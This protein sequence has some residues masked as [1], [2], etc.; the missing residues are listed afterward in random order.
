MRDSFRLLHLSDLHFGLEDRAA[1]AWVA[2]EIARDPPAGV[3]ITGDLTMRARHREFAA[4]ARWIE[5]L[6]VPVSVELGNHDMPY[7]NPWE[8]FADRS[9]TG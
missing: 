3:A 5:N 9:R 7:F 6:G 8:R 1:L 2:Q 4:A